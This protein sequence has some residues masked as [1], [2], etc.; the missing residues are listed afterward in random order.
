VGQDA[1]IIKFGFR[2]GKTATP[3][4]D[5]DRTPGNREVSLDCEVKAD[6]VVT[7]LEDYEITG[8]H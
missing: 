5:A 3:Q 2:T 4:E 1:I 8:L 7:I 6:V